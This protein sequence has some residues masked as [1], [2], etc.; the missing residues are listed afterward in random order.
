M[1]LKIIF[2]LLLLLTG[3]EQATD[4]HSKAPLN[5]SSKS[6]S[7]SPEVESSTN[8]N[9]EASSIKSNSSQ[10]ESLTIEPFDQQ[11]VPTLTKEKTK[12]SAEKLVNSSVNN[13]L[14]H[15]EGIPKIVEGS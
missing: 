9:T 12:D 4:N 8:S 5:E 7:A 10:Q 1:I 13:A 15:Q 14:S 6:F 11:I 2:P 3:C